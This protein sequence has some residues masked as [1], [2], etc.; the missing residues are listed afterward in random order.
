MTGFETF[1][2]WHD[3]DLARPGIVPGRCRTLRD[4]GWDAF[5]SWMS[6][7]N[8]RRTWTSCEYC[9]AESRTYVTFDHDFHVHL[10]LLRSNGPSVVLLRVAGLK[11]SEQAAL[12]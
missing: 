9:R 10:A 11:A 2:W 1:T 12:I 8:V 3:P 4:G 7:W 5:M 6:Q